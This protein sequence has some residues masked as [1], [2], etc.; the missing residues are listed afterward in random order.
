M[1][2]VGACAVGCGELRDDAGVGV[3][4][5][6]REGAD[7]GAGV[8]VVGVGGTVWTVGW[9]EGISVCWAS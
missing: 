8:V 1:G 7:G 6:G 4:A 2:C 3:G 5:V 9:C